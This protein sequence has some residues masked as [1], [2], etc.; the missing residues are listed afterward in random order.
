MELTLKYLARKNTKTNKDL[1]SMYTK[2]PKNPA[3]ADVYFNINERR[4]YIFTG[5]DWALIEDRGVSYGDGEKIF[6]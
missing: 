3:I 1:I 5:T 4:T 6:K 2:A